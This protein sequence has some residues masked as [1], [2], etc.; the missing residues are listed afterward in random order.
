MQ[1]KQYLWESVRIKA[2]VKEEISQI[3]NPNF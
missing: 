3:N 1:Q 2:H